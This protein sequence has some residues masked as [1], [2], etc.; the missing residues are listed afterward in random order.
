MRE[1]TKSIF[2]AGARNYKSSSIKFVTFQLQTLCIIYTEVRNSSSV[3]CSGLIGQYA[4]QSVYTSQM[5]GADYKTGAFVQSV[6]LMI[7]IPTYY[8][9]EENLNQ[10]LMGRYIWIDLPGGEQSY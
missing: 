5:G 4:S 2:V 8:N 6:V 3:S 10:N 7:L 9:Q 1:V